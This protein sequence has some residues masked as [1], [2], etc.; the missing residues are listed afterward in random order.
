MRGAMVTSLCVIFGSIAG[1]SLAQEPAEWPAV[2][3]GKPIVRAQDG[4]ESPRT[5]GAEVPAA[6][7][8]TLGKPVFGQPKGVDPT[9]EAPAPRNEPPVFVER[10]PEPPPLPDAQI[11]P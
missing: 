1:T 3:L 6:Q 5:R 11:R 4:D 10:R 7:L 9:P 8:P 2:R